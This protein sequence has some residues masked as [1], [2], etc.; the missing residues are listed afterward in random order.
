MSGVFA[1]ATRNDNLNDFTE[2]LDLNI[3]SVSAWGDAVA[4][5]GG[6]AEG[7]QQTLDGLTEAVNTFAVKGTHASRRF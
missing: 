6:T 7:F 2:R 3:E 5:N 1:A 4:L